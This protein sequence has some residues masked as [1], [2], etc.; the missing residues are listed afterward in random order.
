MGNTEFK[1]RIDDL[2]LR[3]RWWCCQSVNRNRANNILMFVLQWI[4]Q[5]HQRRDERLNQGYQGIYDE[6]DPQKILEDGKIL[7]I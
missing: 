2:W 7:K 3:L 6:A 1:S 4:S 5:I